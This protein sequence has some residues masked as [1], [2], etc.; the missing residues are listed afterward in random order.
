M[1]K[2]NVEASRRVWDRFLAGDIP[3]TLTFLDP[4]VE[5]YDVPE[6]PGARVYHGH[7]GWL[8]QIATFREAFE[9]IDYRVLE[10][11]DCGESV[12]TVVEASGTGT[13]SGITGTVTYAQLERWRDGKVVSIR[14]FTSREAAL[15]AAGQRE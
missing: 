13:G 10:H 8:E 5:V 14:Y 1:S 4:K 12:V 15:E 9:D 2:E 6:L 3:G 11:I 7:K